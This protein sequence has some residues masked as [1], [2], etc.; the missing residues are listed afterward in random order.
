MHTRASM[1][2]LARFP[3]ATV[4][5]LALS[6]GDKPEDGIRDDVALRDFRSCSELED[7][8]KGQAL[9]DM[10]AQI[11]ELIKGIYYD[12]RGGG[13]PTVPGAAPA[14]APVPAPA[15]PEARDFTTTNTQERDVDEADFVKNDGSRA[16]VLHDRQLVKLDT[17]PPESTRIAWTQ[18]LEGYPVEMFLEGN[19][20]AVFS[21]VNLSQVLSRAGVTLKALPC[22]LARNVAPTGSR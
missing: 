15:P 4:A 17:W 1:R 10:N 2:K 12:S 13:L 22:P 11:D 16:F 14:G 6:C 8:I 21:R 20:V 7:H 9:E 18:P 5:L 19:R 3:L